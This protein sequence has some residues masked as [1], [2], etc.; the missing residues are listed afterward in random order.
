MDNRIIYNR[1]MIF[2]N[3]DIYSLYKYHYTRGKVIKINRCKKLKPIKHK[4]GYLKIVLYDENG[5]SIE[6]ALHRLVAET[7]IPN[8]ENKPQVNHKDGNKLNNCVDNLEWCTAKEN[9][10]HAYNN[11][12]TPH[13]TVEEMNYM[14]SFIRR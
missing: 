1:Y 10:I 9:S 11:Y 14:R 7:F 8:P 6:Y 12:L 3:G 13:K 4:N 2:T 5:K